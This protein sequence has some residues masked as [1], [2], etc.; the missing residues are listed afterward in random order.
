[1]NHMGLDD[2]PTRDKNDCVPGRRKYR[3]VTTGSQVFCLDGFR[4]L[5]FTELTSN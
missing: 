2:R 4:V 1:M 3:L 5:S